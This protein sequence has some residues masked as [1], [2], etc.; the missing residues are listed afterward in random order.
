MKLL[1]TV[2]MTNKGAFLTASRDTRG[3]SNMIVVV[4]VVLVIVIVIVIVG[5]F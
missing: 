3:P 1:C 4:V 2:E 5:I